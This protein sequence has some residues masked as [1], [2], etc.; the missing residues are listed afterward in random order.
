LGTV[1][2]HLVDGVKIERTK[3]VIYLLLYINWL[4]YYGVS[5]MDVINF[6]STAANS[7]EGLYG[8]V[9]QTKK[10]MQF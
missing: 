2:G 6:P 1:V 8:S 3:L 5:I 10:I 9:G 4:L 7:N